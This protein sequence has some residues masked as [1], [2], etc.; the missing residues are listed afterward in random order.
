[1]AGPGRSPTGSSGATKSKYD[2]DDSSSPRY[3]P[4]FN[5]RY[6]AKAC[7]TAARN[8]FDNGA[9][10]VKVQAM[11]GH[12]S[13]ETTARYVGAYLDDADTAVDRINY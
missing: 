8:A 3:R 9:S 1:M 2:A 11:L 6:S 7:R 5:T 13:P 12:S 10:L 4:V